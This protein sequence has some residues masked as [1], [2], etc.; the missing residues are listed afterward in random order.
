M[1][2]CQST[3]GSYEKV[4]IPTRVAQYASR[5]LRMRDSTYALPLVTFVSATGLDSNSCSQ[6]SPCAASE[7]TLFV[8]NG[9]ITIDGKG[10]ASVS[11]NSGQ[12]IAVNSGSTDTI[13]LN[14][15]A[16]VRIPGCKQ[17]GVTRSLKRFMNR[18]VA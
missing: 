1:Y 4:E 12:A 11:V 8:I 15:R 2:Y 5:L 16:G 9:S 17:P 14:R 18:S 7:G 6:A 13:V 10:L 3:G